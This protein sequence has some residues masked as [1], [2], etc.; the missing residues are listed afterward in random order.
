MS[1]GCQGDAVPEGD[2]QA[3]AAGDVTAEAKADRQT[4]PAAEHITLTGDEPSAA[5]KF[6]AGKPGVLTRVSLALALVD[7]SGADSFLET[8]LTV[9]WDP[10][11]EENRTPVAAVSISC[12]DAN[13]DPAEQSDQNLVTATGRDDLDSAVVT[14]NNRGELRYFGAIAGDQVGVA[15][16]SCIARASMADHVAAGAGFRSLVFD[17]LPIWRGADW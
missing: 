14:M 3:V 5:R 10:A 8:Y 7:T 11:Q 13:G 4:K 9:N 15:P 1:A 2:D 17:L 12:I 16:L 6:T